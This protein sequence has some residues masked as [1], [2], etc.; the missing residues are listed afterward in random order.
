ML[1]AETLCGLLNDEIRIL[2]FGRI[3]PQG[4]GTISV[5]VIVKLLAGLPAVQQLLLS[6]HLLRLLG[7]SQALHTE[8]L[9]RH[10]RGNPGASSSSSGSGSRRGRI[11]RSQPTP[12]AANL[13]AAAAAAAGGGPSAAAA[14]LLQAVGITWP[15]REVKLQPP[16][17]QVFEFAML[18]SMR[19]V[20][21]VWFS[22]MRQL[23]AEKQ[24]SRQVCSSSSS[25]SS[26]GSSRTE[27]TRHRAPGIAANAE[28]PQEVAP[29][30]QKQVQ[31]Q[32]LCVVGPA[33]RIL[34]QQLLQPWA[35]LQVQQLLLLVDPDAGSNCTY[36][37]L[38]ILSTLDYLDPAVA[39]SAQL[40]LLQP[41]LLQMLPHAQAIS[42]RVREGC[43][44]DGSG[45]SSSN[46]R[47]SRRSSRS[48]NACSTSGSGAS[49]MHAMM[50]GGGMWQL[51]MVLAEAG[52]I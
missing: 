37:L 32:Q 48:S 30:Q 11:S 33:S 3:E 1:V 5:D 14:A 6:P 19:L 46:S 35:L 26:S 49:G 22:W 12:G 25:S 28:P 47:S 29:Q 52:V 15:C 24:Q 10:V 43:A 42:C 23:E 2:H 34:L 44:A 45:S 51:I 16:N 13:A 27:T 41:V 31:E 8:L 36:G 17:M 4:P 38:S 21:S 39:S 9:Q 7:A 18:Q 20:Q 40:S 50:I